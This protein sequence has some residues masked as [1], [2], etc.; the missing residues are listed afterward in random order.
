MIDLDITQTNQ[1]IDRLL[2]R[3]ENPRHRYLL[4]TYHRHRYLEIAG[5]YE[6]I[7]VPE[8]TVPAPEYHFYTAGVPLTLSGRAT[9]EDLYALWTQT[10]E[11]I[12]YAED[13]RLA[14]GDNLICSDAIAYQQH[15]APALVVRGLL[16]DDLEATY[17][18]RTR[19]IM[20]WGYDDRGRL[21]GENVWELDP[22]S[23]TTIKLDPADVLT[24][25]AAAELLAA[26][27]QPLPPF[28]EETMAVQ[29]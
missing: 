11:C 19:Q 1:A 20:I 27:I 7:F 29:R 13:E 10:S 26:H 16:V 3:T 23:A 4:Q 21:L 6:E 17:L 14:V 9:I 22:S 2:E 25:A 5:R 18:R 12:F 24:P 8:M 15:P 28:D